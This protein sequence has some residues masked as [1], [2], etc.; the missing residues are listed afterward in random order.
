MDCDIIWPLGI[1]LTREARQ[2]KKGPSRTDEVHIQ[3][4]QGD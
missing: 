3:E 4:V 2:K 1:M